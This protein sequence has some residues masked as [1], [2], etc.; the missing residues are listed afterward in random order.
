MELPIRNRRLVLPELGKLVIS[1]PILRPVVFC[2]SQR[3]KEDVKEFMREVRH[4]ADILIMEPDFRRHRKKM[5]RKTEKRRLES[6]SYKVRVPGMAMG[7]VERLRKVKNYGGTCFI[8]NPGGYV[9]LNTFGE[10]FLAS[11][12]LEMVVFALEPHHQKE[13]IFDDFVDFFV[14]TPEEFIA[15][16]RLFGVTQSIEVV[17]Q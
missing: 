15:K 17:K 5:I 11:Q 10:F 1:R 13:V 6:W 3:F 16:Q 4:L 14:K 2:T 12:E 8:F 9:G 7:H